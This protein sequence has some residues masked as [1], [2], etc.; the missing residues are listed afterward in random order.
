MSMFVQSE[1]RAFLNKSR[2]FTTQKLPFFSSFRLYF[3]IGKNTNRSIS[4]K[5]NVKIFVSQWILYQILVTLKVEPVLYSAQFFGAVHASR[6]VW[7]QKNSGP[8]FLYVFQLAIL[9]HSPKNSDRA[10]SGTSILCFWLWFSIGPSSDRHSKKKHFF[11]KFWLKTYAH[12][13]SCTICDKSLQQHFLI[14]SLV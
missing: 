4:K 7:L 6:T 14:W 8:I 1:F 2:Q 13:D 5:A 9:H 11:C 12:V 10:T 3:Y